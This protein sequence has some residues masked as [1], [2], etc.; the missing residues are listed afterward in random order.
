MKPPLSLFGVRIQLWIVWRE[1]P[2]SA[3]ISAIGRPLV[4]VRSII[5]RRSCS[6]CRGLRT[7]SLL[8]FERLKRTRP[9]PA[10]LGR[11]GVD[12]YG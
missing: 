5:A 12:G 4:S 11:R 8:H 10:A 7:L 2:S 6:V 9:M 3:A 1:I